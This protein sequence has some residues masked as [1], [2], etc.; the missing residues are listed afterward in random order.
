MQSVLVFCGAWKETLLIYGQDGLQVGAAARFKDRRSK[1]GYSAHYELRDS[2]LMCIVRDMTPGGFRT[3]RLRFAVLTADEAEI[4]TI[5]RSEGATDRYEIAVDGRPAATIQCI[6]WVPIAVRRSSAGRRSSTSTILLG[7][8][9]ALYDRLT[10]KVW[11]IDTA[12]GERVARVTYLA[13]RRI[14]GSEEVAYVL[15]LDGVRTKPVGP[16]QSPF[17]WR[18]TPGSLTSTAAAGKALWPRSIVRDSWGDSRCRFG[19]A[20]AGSRP[21]RSARSGMRCCV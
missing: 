21:T 17:A 6:E 15:E 13:A 18:R 2:E 7:K 10:A 8:A 11:T 4:G 12:S 3:H 20:A 14:P 9:Q 16:W 1:V 19:R 5:T